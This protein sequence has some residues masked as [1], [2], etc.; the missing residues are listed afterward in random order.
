[1]SRP[2]RAGLGFEYPG[3]C[4]GLSLGRAVGAF[5]CAIPDF[6]PRGERIDVAEDS[7]PVGE[8]F[9]TSDDSIPAGD[10][11]KMRSE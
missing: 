5:A 1:M 4:P 7:L 8:S 11:I 6:V 2:F 10:R 3:R 9:P